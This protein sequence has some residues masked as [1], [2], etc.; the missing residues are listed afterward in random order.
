MMES[1]TGHGFIH[2]S[3]EIKILILYILARL[4]KPVAFD[5][6]ASLASCDGGVGYFDF[7]DCLADLVRT[8]HVSLTG[9]AYEITEKGRK[10]GAVTETD[11]PYPVRL[12]ADKAAAATAFRQ[13]REQLV[14]ARHDIRPHGGCAVTLALSDGQEELME[15]RLHTADEKQAAAIEENFRRDAEKLYA[16]LMEALTAPEKE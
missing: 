8:E 13:T 9:Q 6:L 1:A 15:L 7:A 5:E 14:T 11:L 12:R 3:L 4:P 16:D 2:S 10:N